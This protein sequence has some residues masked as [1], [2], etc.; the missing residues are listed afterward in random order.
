MYLLFLYAKSA[1]KKT[2]TIIFHT[3]HTRN[4][5]T[6]RLILY[7]EVGTKIYYKH[8]IVHFYVPRTHEIVNGQCIYIKKKINIKPRYYRR[9]VIS[10]KCVSID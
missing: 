5:Y 1:T 2:H 3:A 7:I 9:S 6:H 10:F 8:N 4:S